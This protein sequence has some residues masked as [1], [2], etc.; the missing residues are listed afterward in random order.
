[1][2]KLQIATVVVLSFIA[3]PALTANTSKV[4]PVPAIGTAVA[5]FTAKDFLGKTY[6]LSEVGN[7]KIVV[8]AFVGVE[9]PLAKLYTPRLVELAKKYQSHGVVF[10]GVDSNRQDAATEIAAYV[11]IHNVNFPVLKDLR[12]KIADLVGATRTPQVVVLDAKRMIRYRGRIDDQ[13]GVVPN[14]P[15]ANYQKAKPVKNDLAAALDDILADRQ[16][17]Q[18]ETAAC[19]CLL[20][21]DHEPAANAAVTYTKDVAAILNKNCVFCHRPGQIAPFAL[22][23]F[24]EAAGWSDMIAEVTQARRM[25][26]WHADPQ[27]G[28]FS[29]DCRLSEANKQI[30]AKWAES[31]AGREYQGSPRAAEVRGRL[32]D[33]EAGRNP[34]HAKAVQHP[35]NRRRR[36][37]EFRD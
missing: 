36:I 29:N 19:G 32:A 6:R 14:N 2:G 26:P 17:S 34:L 8:L 23:N 7:G 30:L 1:M 28:A 4:A 31:G 5:D 16:V 24:E 22:T 3:T 15:T 13:F 35:G 25:P 21:R 37:S 11:R 27:F 20:G 18:Q 9:C 10:L 33:P 12:Q